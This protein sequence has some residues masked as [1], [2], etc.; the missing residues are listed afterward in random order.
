MK[1]LKQIREEHDNKFLTLVTEQSGEL[2]GEKIANRAGSSAKFAPAQSNL[3]SN[4][5]VVPSAKEMPMMLIFRRLQYKIY[6]NNQVVALYYSSMI[7]KY[8]SVPYGPGGN[9]NLSE[10]EIIDSI[11]EGW[12]DVNRRDKTDGMSQAA[13]NAY[14]RENPGSKLK[15][16][17][18]EKNPT[19]KRAARRKAFCSRMSGMK[20]RLTSAETARDPDSRINKALR[21][22]NCEESINEEKWYEKPW[23]DY[24]GLG[25]A[26]KTATELTPGASAYQKTKEGD[27][28]GA[29]KSAA[30]DVALGGAAK[31]AGKAIK[32]Y[33]AWRA[34]KTA[35]KAGEAAVK[36]DASA[37]ATAAPKPKPAAP[38]ISPTVAAAG[39]AAAGAVGS[40][41]VSKA[42]D[43]AKAALTG[44]EFGA[45]KLGGME[46]PSRVKTG[47]AWEK[48]S[49]EDKVFK[50]KM[51]GAAL[52]DVEATKKALHVRENRISDLKKMVRENIDSR[53]ITIN[54]RTVTLNN[55][56]AKRI[57]EVYDSVNAKNKKIVESMLNEDLE[58]FKK[59]LNFTIR[60]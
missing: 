46:R 2:L 28:A 39:G 12:E 48:A 30:I 22:W 51:R 27:Y 34:G 29:A 1:T 35:K 23:M 33:R 52:K 37:I 17:V 21:R 5:N 7:D 44:P 43:M 45:T 36:R 47:S 32:S 18:T 60:N 42:V 25:G 59:L 9:L 57:V 13:V 15:T 49:S 6:P 4:I 20:K 40:G 54:G 55:S 16:A 19:G 8:L 26:V 14:R 41:V 50:S 31:L 24:S 3:K 10:A 56:M 58:S 38:R 11:D 53:D